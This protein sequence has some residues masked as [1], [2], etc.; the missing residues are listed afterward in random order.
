M[1]IH[2]YNE[3]SQGTC[4]LRVSKLL[5][6]ISKVVEEIELHAAGRSPLKPDDLWPQFLMMMLII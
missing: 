1:V 5:E 3:K 6:G 4:W 2:E